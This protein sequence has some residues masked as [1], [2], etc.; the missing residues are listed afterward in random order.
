MPEDQRPTFGSH[1]A[2]PLLSS[3]ISGVA[4]AKGTGERLSAPSQP[5]PPPT[6]TQWPRQENPTP[7]VF[8]V[9]DTRLSSVFRNS[10]KFSQMNRGTISVSGGGANFMVAPNLRPSETIMRGIAINAVHDMTATGITPLPAVM[11]V[12]LA[13][14][15]MRLGSKP[16]DVREGWQVYIHS[17]VKGSNR[18]GK[19]MIHP[20]LQAR[21]TAA[22]FEHHMRLRCAEMALL[23]NYWYDN[24]AILQTQH[25]KINPYGDKVYMLSYN[26]ADFADGRDARGR[27]IN[28]CHHEP[29][30]ACR[31]RGC[32]KT[33]NCGCRDILDLLGVEVTGKGEPGE[34]NPAVWREQEA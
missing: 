22:K 14:S 2:I 11:G 28:P 34:Q 8:S 12:L 20:D 18:G 31:N 33:S 27:Y 5:P 23:S 16:A 17:S 30:G 9:E 19:T 24:D 21:I 15:Q 25:G 29:Q 32:S 10:G 1:V 4:G 3:I 26:S 13:K 6:T 7:T